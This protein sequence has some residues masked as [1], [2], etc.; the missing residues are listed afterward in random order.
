LEALARINPR[1]KLRVVD[2]GSWESAVAQQYSIR[3]LPTVWLYEDGEVYSKDL[4]TILQKLERL[5]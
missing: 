5:K 3:S 2:V 1:V 4:K